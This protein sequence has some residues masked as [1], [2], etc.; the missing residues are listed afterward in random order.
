MTT[1]RKTPATKLTPMT[2]LKEYTAST[3]QSFE[4]NI[5]QATDPQ[6]RKDQRTYCNIMLWEADVAQK[7]LLKPSAISMI[8]QLMP[9]VS[10]RVLTLPGTGVWIVLDTPKSTNLYFSSIPHA[11]TSYLEAHPREQLPRGFQAVVNMPW[12]WNL[13]IT[14]IGEHPLSY[15]YDAE[16]D[17]WTFNKIDLCPTKLCEKLSEDEHKFSSWHMC[18]VCKPKFD[19]WTAFFPTALMGV[20]RD[21]AEEQEIT[22]PVTRT[23][24]ETR[25]RRTDQGTRETNIS[26]TYHIITFDISIKPAPIHTEPAEHHEIS[27]PTWRERAIEEETILYVDKHIEEFERTYRHERY[28]NMRG[29]TITVQSHDKRVPRSV[30][31]LKQT[32]YQAIAEHK[33]G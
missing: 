11:T 4:R 31:R 17:L 2:Y 15:V 22:A 33:K 3:I 18:D 7:Y 9:P 21:F 24:R 20:N 8:A 13:E 6:E 5:A 19:Y 1:K 10:S 16:K 27:H 23:E 30:K 32:I 25:K 29:K 28:V 14:A 12:I 26:H